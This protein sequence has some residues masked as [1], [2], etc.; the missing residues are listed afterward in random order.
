LY[1]N[2]LACCYLAAPEDSEPVLSREFH[3]QCESEA[4]DCDDVLT[5][6]LLAV[7]S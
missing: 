6:L 5:A 7:P 1:L 4:V 2:A 3:L